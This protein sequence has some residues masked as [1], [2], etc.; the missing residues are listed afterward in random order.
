MNSSR[1]PPCCGLGG[2]YYYCRGRRWQRHY[3]FHCR[4]FEWVS[5]AV[6]WKHSPLQVRSWE[7]NIPVPTRMKML[8]SSSPSS[9]SP[10]A[11]FLASFVVKRERTEQKKQKKNQSEIKKRNGMGAWRI[12]ND[13]VFLFTLSTKSAQ[14]AHTVFRGGGRSFCF[15]Y[16]L[17]HSTVECTIST[18]IKVPGSILSIFRRNTATFL[19]YLSRSASILCVS[20][21]LLISGT[22]H[23]IVHRTKQ[24]PF[25]IFLTYVVGMCLSLSLSSISFGS[26]QLTTFNIVPTAYCV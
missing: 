10:S 11:P 24:E 5:V 3:R 16:V 6:S 13:G 26:A 21:G 20:D 7:S 1:H 23:S 14:I 22:V 15:R 25:A 4:P 12:G 18:E 2:C 19:K 9:L 17:V 8:S